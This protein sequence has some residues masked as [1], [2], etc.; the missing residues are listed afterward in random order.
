MPLVIFTFL[1]AA[2][3][4][5]YSLYAIKVA[6]TAAGKRKATFFLENI[7]SGGIRYQIEKG[8]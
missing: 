7:G 5:G 6:C 3:A 1:L 4:H 2:E 8:R